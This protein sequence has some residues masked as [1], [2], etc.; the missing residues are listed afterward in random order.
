MLSTSKNLIDAGGRKAKISP[1]NSMNGMPYSSPRP[2]SPRLNKST[3]SVSPSNSLN[4]SANLD[5][6]DILNTSDA[7]VESSTPR[8][9]PSPVL[10]PPPSSNM[11]ETV[12]FSTSTTD[13][14]RNFTMK[15]T[16]NVF[17]S[18]GKLEAQIITTETLSVTTPNDSEEVDNE[19]E[20]SEASS[21]SQSQSQSQLSDTGIVPLQPALKESGNNSLLLA[22]LELSTS[23]PTEVG[24]Q[25]ISPPA[26]ANNTTSL[27]AAWDNDSASVG[28][29]EDLLNN[30]LGMQ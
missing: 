25:L 28:F 8:N 3:D 26:S 2:S 21:Q 4:N 23:E 17:T 19:S 10:M 11:T 13:G 15:V 24:V 1:R 29:D 30:W 22:D 5:I 6:S 18:D 7:S 12:S 20:E 14:A 16:D 27:T 9:V